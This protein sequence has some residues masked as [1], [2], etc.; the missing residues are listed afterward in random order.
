MFGLF[1]TGQ[2]P[3]REPGQGVMVVA[4]LNARVQPLDRGDFYEDPLDVELRQRGLGQVTGGGTQLADEPDGI[5]FCDVEIL[6][7]DDTPST[8]EQ[9]AQILD[10]IGVPKGSRLM[11]EGQEDV[12]F[13]RQEGLGLFVNGT[14]LPAEVYAS[15]DINHVIAECERLMGGVGAKRGHWEGSRETAIYFYGE[16]FAGMRDAIAGFVAEYPLLERARVVQI[17]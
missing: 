13:G 11:A 6:A 1:G 17:A 8:L 16:S 9:I 5:A 10:G 2:E 4:R 3:E 15:S 12:S 14:D 7:V